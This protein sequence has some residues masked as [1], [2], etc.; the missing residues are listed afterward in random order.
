MPRNAV[1]LPLS[2]MEQVA[3]IGVVLP[4]GRRGAVLRPAALRPHF[5]DLM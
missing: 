5:T 1:G 4:R 2:V 3:L